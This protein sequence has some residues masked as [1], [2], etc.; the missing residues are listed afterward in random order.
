MKTLVIGRAGLVIGGI[1]TR[2][3][4]GCA[5]LGDGSDSGE[6]PT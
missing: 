1:A 2:L 3:A 6:P 5:V 4:V